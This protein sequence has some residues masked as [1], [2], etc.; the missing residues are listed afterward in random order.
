MGCVVQN[1]DV[2]Y[3]EKIRVTT[4]VVSWSGDHG[5]LL[6]TQAHGYEFEVVPVTPF[7]SKR[8]HHNTPPSAGCGIAMEP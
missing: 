5:G 4:K 1:P 3:P 6:L 8:R 7:F 2:G